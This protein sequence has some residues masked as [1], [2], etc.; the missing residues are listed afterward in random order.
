MS[1]N[2]TDGGSGL[3]ISDIV[4]RVIA[5]IWTRLIAGI[6]LIG[7]SIGSGIITLGDSLQSGTIEPISFIA[8]SV[9]SIGDDL[10]VLA[11]EIDASLI[12]LADGAGVAAPLVVV[13]VYAITGATLAI[14]IT[15]ILSLIARVI[16]I[17]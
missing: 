13:V 4:D 7:G 16:P 6:L 5:R 2:S 10:I 12:A 17:L 15:L 9:G 1:P 11:V 3:S 14:A 8:G